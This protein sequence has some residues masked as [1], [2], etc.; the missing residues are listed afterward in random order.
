MPTA[1]A[2][3]VAVA[4]SAAP[5][6][7]RLFTEMEGLRVRAALRNVGPAPVTLTVGDRCAGPAFALIV[8]GK[9]RPFVGPVRHCLR[10]QPQQRTLPPGGQYAILSD[11]LDGRHHTIVV[12]FG[13]VLSP[14]LVVPTLVRVDL[15][16]AATAKVRAG[17]PVDVELAHVNRSPEEITVPACGEDRLLVDGHEQPLPP[18]PGVVCTPSPRVLKVRGAF[19][20]RAQLSLPPG[21]HLLRARWRE[22]QSNDVTVDVSQ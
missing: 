4:A 9:R 21:R 10:P 16:L 20:V 19:V 17:Q 13:A 6:D 3:L 12:Q 2:I 14:P 22:T 15:R 5:A 7:L 18:A 8:D 11:S 1:I